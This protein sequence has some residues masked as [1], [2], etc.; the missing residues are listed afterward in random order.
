MTFTSPWRSLPLTSFFLVLL[1]QY[2][3]EFHQSEKNGSCHVG[4]R[5]ALHRRAAF[6]TASTN[7]AAEVHKRHGP[8]RPPKMTYRGSTGVCSTGSTDCG[9]RCGG[10]P[11]NIAL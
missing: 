11:E 6:P 2:R 1:N 5:F 4:F 9:A 3:A 8:L 7:F 10:C